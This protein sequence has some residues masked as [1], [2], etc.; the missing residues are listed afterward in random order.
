MKAYI[1]GNWKLLRLPV[2]FGSGDWELY[3]LDQDPGE[4][5]DVSHKYQAKKAELLKAWQLYAER[6]EV[7]DH[8]G[9]FDAMYRKVYGIAN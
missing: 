5:H 1:Q 4:V 9:R 6:N 3:N 8:K 2:P 7:F